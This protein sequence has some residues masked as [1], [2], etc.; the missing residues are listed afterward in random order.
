MLANPRTIKMLGNTR[1]ILELVES[2]SGSYYIIV[3]KD[4]VKTFS[5]PIK[6]LGAALY[7]FDI[8]LNDLIG[9]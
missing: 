1:F 7:L 2:L 5:N 8:K 9:Q 6:D 3:E 4:E